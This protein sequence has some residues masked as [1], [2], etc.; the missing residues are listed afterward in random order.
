MLVGSPRKLDRM[1]TVPL[2]GKDELQL[3]VERFRKVDHLQHNVFNHCFQAEGRDKS[4]EISQEFLCKLLPVLD[5]H[6]E[7]KAEELI[8]IF[9]LLPQWLSTRDARGTVRGPKDSRSN[10]K[11]VAAGFS[12]VRFVFFSDS[13]LG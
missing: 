2:C 11:T 5:R 9:S 6:K 12:A 8:E 1:E 7:L 10:Y 4:E 3:D 13:I